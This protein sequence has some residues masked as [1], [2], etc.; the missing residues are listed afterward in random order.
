MKIG[1]IIQARTSSTR[2]PE[3]VLKNLPFD[4]DITVL[5]QV[6]HRLKRSKILD[7]IIIATTTD[8]N[9]E[10]IINIAEK[11]EIPWF[12][13]SKYNVL[14][15]YYLAAKENELDIIIRITSDCPC[16]DPEIVDLIIENHLTVNAD[17]T[18]NSLVRT[19]PHGLDM[20]VITFKS[21][22]KAYFEATTDFEREHVTPFIY[23]TNPQLFKINSF[24]AEKELKHPDIRIT[25]DTEEDY[26]LLCSVFD[27]LYY[28]D[29]FFNSK[30]I[31]ILFNQKPWL[32]IINKKIVQKKIFDT[33]EEEIIEAKKILD[34]QELKRAKEILNDYQSVKK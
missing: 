20:E 31:I 10:K 22:Q 11:E 16:V 14:K 28:N 27:Y 17:Y 12:R 34:L 4:S 24:M 21:L 32:K 3:K 6:I 18:S 8:E 15:R 2:L 1:A 26:A 30:D 25:L 7:E 23:R 29:P 9:D 13:G 19:F 33:V 5:E